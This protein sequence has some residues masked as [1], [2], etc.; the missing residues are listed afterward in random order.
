[1]TSANRPFFISVAAELENYELYW[2]VKDDVE[3]YLPVSSFNSE[4]EII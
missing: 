4:F 2:L 3:K 1:L